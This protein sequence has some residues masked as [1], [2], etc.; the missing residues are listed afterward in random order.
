VLKPQAIRP[1]AIWGGEPKR[2]STEHN[3]V[4][5]EAFKR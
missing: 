4:H 3:S 5:D 1:V 2:A